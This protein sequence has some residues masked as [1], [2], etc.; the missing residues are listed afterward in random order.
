VRGHFLYPSPF[1]EPEAFIARLIAELAQRKIDVLMPVFEET[2]LI[3]KYKDRLAPHVKLAVPDYAQ[4][5]TAH[6]KDVWEGLA[7]RLDIPVPAT[8]DIAGLRSGRV[9][10]SQ[11]AFPVLI[12]PKQGGG[13]WGIEEMPSAAALEQALGG[14]SWHQK[15]WDRF[16][17]QEK[18]S[19]VT[20]CVAMLFG[21]G[22]WKATVAY[23][24]LRDYPV[25][26][27]QA[28]LRVS[29]RSA[30]AEACLRRLGGCSS[31]WRGTA[32]A[33]RTSSSTGKGA[34]T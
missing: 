21:H 28:T 1:R 31:T 11:L 7:R 12:K 34:P 14:D 6:N 15:P 5:L 8:H 25:T 16:F 9:P 33:R 23:Q 29:L 20:H 4:I 24:Q 2:F 18:I 10:L 26:G 30:R 22:A 17:V 32:P 27:G 3:A 19:G 13:A